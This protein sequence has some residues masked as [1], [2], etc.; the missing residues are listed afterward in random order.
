MPIRGKKVFS[1]KR[2][3]FVGSSESIVPSSA[4]I[5]K[6][7]LGFVALLNTP[8]KLPESR[9]SFQIHSFSNSFQAD[10]NDSAPDAYPVSKPIKQQKWQVDLKSPTK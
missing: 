6:N 1:V 9:K 8:G 7:A 3:F 2:A 10:P 4:H 5:Q